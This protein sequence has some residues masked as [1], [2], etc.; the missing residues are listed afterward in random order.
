MKNYDFK[1]IDII[2][3]TPRNGV[4]YTKKIDVELFVSRRTS[5]ITLSA[6]GLYLKKWIVDN[7]SSYKAAHAFDYFYEDD[8]G[9]VYDLIVFS[10]SNKK[11]YTSLTEFLNNTDFDN[12][13]PYNGQKDYHK[14]MK[15]EGGLTIQETVKCK[16]IPNSV[17]KDKNTLGFETWC[18]LIDN[19]E[20]RYWIWG[21]TIYFESGSDAMAFKLRWL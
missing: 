7:L 3:D 6:M 8:D 14:V 5:N 15:D 17:F 1:L 20:S 21:G 2:K 10:V 9:D 19:L 18:W 4:H 11:A 13:T 12:L 16:Q